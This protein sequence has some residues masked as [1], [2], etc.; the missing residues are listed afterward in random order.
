MNATG[1]GLVQQKGDENIADHDADV[2]SAKIVSIPFLA[3]LHTQTRLLTFRGQGL[4]RQ[5]ENSHGLPA[6]ANKS[7]RSLWY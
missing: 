1:P 6:G 4:Y 3:E 2:L 7:V 5:I